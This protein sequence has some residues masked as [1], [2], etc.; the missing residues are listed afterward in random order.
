MNKREKEVLQAQIDHEKEVLKRL[1]ESY[2]DALGEINNKLEILMA[3]Q[4]ADMQH[5]IYQREYQKALKA[6]VETILETLHN[7]EFE[8]VSEFLAK[9]YEEGFIGA[10]YSMH[11]QGAPIIM[12]IDHE[13]VARAIQHE[14]QLTSSLYDELGIDTKRLSKQIAGEISRGISSGMMYG[15]IARN[16]ASY[17]KVPM[18]RAMLIARTEAHRIQA[19]ATVDAQYKARAHGVDVVKQWD[20][21]LDGK[22]RPNHRELDGQVRELEE[23]FEVSGYKP[24]HPGDFGDPAEDCNCR[25][26][27]LPRVRSALKDDFTKW[28]KDDDGTRMVNIKADDYDD[29]KKEFWNNIDNQKQNK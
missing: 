2:Q 25:C 29:F 6:Q 16:I 19:K 13:L 17:S 23:S 14:T 5:V 10:M 22:T 21:N 4:D 3:R 28:V 12:P 1:E 9:A 15:E 26:C 27:I 24:K 8:T 18:N 20:A 11:G 7:N